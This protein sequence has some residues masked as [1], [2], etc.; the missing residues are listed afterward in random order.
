MSAPSA[1]PKH[2]ANGCVSDC[3][4]NK[5]KPKDI[6][7]AQPSDTLN[8]TLS[9]TLSDTLNGTLKNDTSDCFS[10]CYDDLCKQGDTLN[11]TLSDTLNGKIE[12]EGFFKEK[13]TDKEKEPDKE[14]E[15]NKEE[16]INQEKEINKEKESVLKRATPNFKKPSLEEIG[17]YVFSA[18]LNVDAEKFFDYYESNGWMVGRTKM[19]NWKAA[20]R[21]W[22]R[23]QSK[24]QNND[25]NTYRTADGQV[26]YR[27]RDWKN[28]SFS[29][30]IEG[31]KEAIDAGCAMAEIDKKRKEIEEAELW[32]NFNL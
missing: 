13:E 20:A 15:R 10:E 1:T 12:E 6:V 9:G 22:S 14:E 8:D 24:N 29:E 3:Y 16:G 7:C 5:Q 26:I 27:K 28:Q 19:K 32:K 2:F 25:V 18:N 31:L 17:D 23:N 11:G 30:K 21:N 4:N